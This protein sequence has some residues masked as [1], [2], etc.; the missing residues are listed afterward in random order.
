MVEV[1]KAGWTTQRITSDKIRVGDELNV[2]WL[3]D[4]LDDRYVRVEE[5][6][7]HERAGLVRVRFEGREVTVGTGQP[8]MV[9]FEGTVPR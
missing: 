3:D 6:E 5:V 2:W 9:R 4:E 8:V 7:V 1:A